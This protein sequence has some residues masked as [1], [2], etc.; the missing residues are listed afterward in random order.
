MKPMLLDDDETNVVQ[1]TIAIPILTTVFPSRV[2]RPQTTGLLFLL[3]QLLVFPPWFSFSF[4]K[5]MNE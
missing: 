4:L 1:Q 2:T 3:H 5:E